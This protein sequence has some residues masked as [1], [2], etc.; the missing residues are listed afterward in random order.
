MLALKKLYLVLLVFSDVNM[1]DSIK[2]IRFTLAIRK[3]RLI[4]RT[5][6]AIT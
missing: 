2:S 1:C 4:S 3:Q 6:L 5:N